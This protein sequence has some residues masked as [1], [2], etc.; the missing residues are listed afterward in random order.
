MSSPAEG[1]HNPWQPAPDLR[2]PLLLGAL[3]A[4]AAGILG[5][6]SG[7]LSLWEGPG[8][9]LAVSEMLDWIALVPLL[10]VLWA[11]WKVSLAIGSPALR[12]SALGVFGGLVLFDLLTLVDLA[13]PASWWPVVVWVVTGIGLVV[14]GIVIFSLEKI[15]AGVAKAD[16]APPDSDKPASE[17]DVPATTTRA[18]NP[19]RPAEEETTV[20]LEGSDSPS[21]SKAGCAGLT[22]GA[23]VLV[24]L[25]ILG[26]VI[27]LRKFGG[28]I[29]GAGTV[30]VGAG[31]LVVLAACAL[32]EVG[33][34]IWFAVCKIRQRGKLGNLAILVGTVE[35]LLL[36][37]AA[38]MLA[39]L[40]VDVVQ[41]VLQ[42]GAADDAVEGVGARW[43]PTLALA[44]LAA[45]GLWA[46]VTALL[47]LR[48]RQRTPADAY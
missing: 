14:V 28:R 9:R 40:M 20:K 29:A 16:A 15:E 1:L 5:A 8:Q 36:L 10:G 12:K 30:I 26:R 23:A 34:W 6:A 42:P 18:G 25:R 39:W 17:Q 46:G 21:K 43:Q 13:D 41:T 45:N 22:V 3:S 11:Y 44:T 19:A 35:L 32:M 38:G 31:G 7:V 33:F 2:R 37:G 27:R 4:L 24:V 48:L 47:F